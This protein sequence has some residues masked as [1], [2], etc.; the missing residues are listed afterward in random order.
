MFGKAGVGSDVEKDNI[1]GGYATVILPLQPDGM[2]PSLS[3]RAGK[4]APF[5]EL[6]AL[7]AGVKLRLEK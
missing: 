7:A 4:K 3:V 2:G 6:T 1:F 5:D